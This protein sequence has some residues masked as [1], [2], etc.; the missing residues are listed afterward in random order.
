MILQSVAIVGGAGYIGSHVAKAFRDDGFEVHILDNL[1]AGAKG[2]VLSG[3]IFHHCDILVPSSLDRFFGTQKVAGVVHLAA[4][5]AVGESMNIPLV[6]TEANVI[7][8]HNVLASMYRYGCKHFIYSSS[9][10][11]YGTPDY[12]PIDEDHPL[13]PDNYYGYTKKC[14]EEM[15]SWYGKLVGISSIS[16][17]Y[18]NAVGY[19]HAGE[20]RGIESNPNNLL[21]RVMECAIGVRDHIDVFGVD[22]DTEDGT[23][24]RDY[25]HVSDLANAHLLAMKYALTCSEKACTHSLNL[26]SEKGASVYEIIKASREITGRKIPTKEVVRR[27]GDP[28]TL[29]ASSQQAME[30]LGWTP[31]HTDI[32]DMIETTWEIYKELESAY[33][34]SKNRT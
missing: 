3:T 9:A 10:A 2:N 7:G 1:S 25:V 6:Y 5:K 13:N 23:G 29:I 17:R 34:A 21:P 33:Y 24:V 19:D 26:G 14:S 15:I 30:I 28:A 16:L 22:F 8:T 12:L 4:R 11:V 32:R 31:K 27:P 18:F 20:I